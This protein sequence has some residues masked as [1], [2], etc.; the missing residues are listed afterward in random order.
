MITM[1][2]TGATATL[3]SAER[4]LTARRRLVTTI[5]G[6]EV[7]A[8]GRWTALPGELDSGERLEGGG[9]HVP[10]GDLADVSLSLAMG[11]AALECRLAR[12][13]RLG[14]WALLGSFRS[15]DRSVDVVA[16]ARYHGVFAGGG[17]PI[18]LVSIVHVAAAGRRLRLRHPP[19]SIVGHVNFRL[20]PTS[21][22]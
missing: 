8:A 11:G 21:P 9:L 12:A 10:G 19:V 20:Q 22:G 1:N 17:G 7:P 15:A 16:S 2:A 18:A 3:G 6:V 5:D 13:D 4:G 14:N